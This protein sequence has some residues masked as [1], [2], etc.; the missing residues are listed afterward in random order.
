MEVQKEDWLNPKIEIRETGVK[1]KG[2][3][4][5]EPI[6][7]GENVLVW[8]GKYVD[9]RTAEQETRQGRLVIR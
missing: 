8:G 1:G 3:F 6:T 4:A 9:S 5:T 2:M 7:E